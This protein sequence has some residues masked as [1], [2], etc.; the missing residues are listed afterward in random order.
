MAF[1]RSMWTTD[2]DHAA[3]NQMHT[4]RHRLDEIQPSIGAWTHYGL[5]SLNDNLPSYIVLRGPRR[6]ATRISPGWSYPGQK[7]AGAPLAL[8]GEP[9][10]HGKR[11]PD[12]LP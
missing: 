3:E 12:V 11:S 7:Q 5:G 2:N 6:P 9:L 1:V 8:G 10:P 4:G